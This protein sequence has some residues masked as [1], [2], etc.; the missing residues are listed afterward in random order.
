MY[1]VIM[2]KL[3]LTMES[4]IIEEWH[5]KEGDEVKD[6]DV[7]FEVM[8]DKVSL[9]VESYN[10][11]VLIKILRNEG[12]EVP[13]TEIVAYIGERDEKIPDNIPKKDKAEME[14]N[15]EIMGDALQAGGETPTSK[16]EEKIKEKRIKISPI[17]KKI[18]R[19]NGLDITKIVGSGP[20]GRIVKEDILD[21]IGKNEEEKSNFKK[22]VLSEINIKSSTTISGMRKTI[23]Q[24][25]SLSKATIP[26][27]VQFVEVDATRLIQLR[28]ELKEDFLKRYRIKITYTDFI[29]IA[30][31]IALRENIG[32]NSTLQDETHIIY[33]DINI[34]LAVSVEEGL[35]VPT[36][37]QADKLEIKEI[38]QTR[39]KI[40]EKAKNGKLTLNEIQNGTFTITNLGMLGIRSSTAIINPPQAAILAAGEIYDKPV[41]KNDNTEVRSFMN[42]SVSCDHRIIDGA[43]AAKFLT[44]I[45]G[46][47][48]NPY[49][50]LTRSLFK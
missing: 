18:A 44:R 45:A 3:G 27:L 11:G 29:I 28:E 14:V 49:L 22:G 40:I 17:A 2:P 39:S 7:L 12:E 25:M 13:V 16:T 6:G 24:R 42:L 23:A 4:G 30:S 43:A 33:D 50:I 48:E 46:L 38:A 1:E 34:G 47:L 8:T 5:K 31:A 21:F 36:I 32:I 9:E 15:T 26:H 41:V 37:F 35:I 10:S 19:E 20:R